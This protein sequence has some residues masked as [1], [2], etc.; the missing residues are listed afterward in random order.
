MKESFGQQLVKWM[1]AADV[2]PAELARRIDKSPTYIS[3][4][5]RDMN[6]SSKSGKSQPS[7]L[8]VDKIARALNRSLREAR[9]A[10]GY[11]PPDKDEMPSDDSLN[12]ISVMFYGFNDLADDDKREVLAMVRVIANDMQRRR[13]RKKDETPPHTAR[14][15]RSKPKGSDRR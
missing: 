10:A 4:L 12:E 6:P 7:K 11:A 2:S 3:Y 1:E 13:R 14:S 9:L 8:V 5:M 15:S